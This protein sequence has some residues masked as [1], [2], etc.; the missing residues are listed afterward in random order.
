MKIYV[1]FDSVDSEGYTTGAYGGMVDYE[2]KDVTNNEENAMTFSS[3]E[4]AEKWIAE[5]R[6][7][8]GRGNFTVWSW[9]DDEN[10]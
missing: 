1:N 10:V 8:W 3:E 2:G 7:S 9:P 5:N 6:D 4:E